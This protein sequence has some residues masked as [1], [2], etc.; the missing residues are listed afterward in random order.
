MNLPMF[1]AALLMISA[2]G[3]R[4]AAAQPAG[5]G[6]SSPAATQQFQAALAQAGSFQQLVNQR[7]RP[8]ADPAAVL[9]GWGF[10]LSNDEYLKVIE[11]NSSCVRVYTVSPPDFTDA[12]D[13]MR[14][15][16]ATADEP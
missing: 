16:G 15:M 13:A 10:Q 2:M 5:Q 3:E 11:A 7:V 6:Q 9:R 1:A 12:E 8:A 4:P 14:C